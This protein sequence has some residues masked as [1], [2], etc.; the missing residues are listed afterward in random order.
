MLRAVQSSAL[1][2]CAP[3]SHVSSAV[4][5][6]TEQRRR[7]EEDGFLVVENVLDR[8]RT[9]GPLIAEYEA[10]LDRLWQGWIN[11]GALEPGDPGGSFE[12]RIVTAYRAGLE[13]FQPMDISLP[14]GSITEETP[15]HAGPAVFAM[16]T[17]DRLL[18]VVEAIIGPEI[19]SN[20]IQH[21]RIKPP[22][23]DLRDDELRAHIAA[24]DWHQDRAVTLEE[25][26]E[27]RMVTAWVAM[28]DA[29]VENG[30]LQVI[31]GSHR[32]AM[33]PHCPEA[34]QVGIPADSMAGRQAR[35]LPV[36]AGGV[37]LF[38]PLTIHGSLSN[39]SHSVRWSFD[40]RYNVTG[41]STGRP[42]FPS[43]VA[44]S[45][46]AP[47]TVLR[48]PDAWRRMWKAARSRLAQQETTTIHRW[49]PDAAHCA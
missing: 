44:R 30:C 48:D 47:E 38:H 33:I 36:G 16:M 34:G 2:C 4:S 15:F 41:E 45:A 40:I 22:A 12:E 24:T 3:Q 26:D 29:T 32:G 1:R 18:D 19:T 11:S 31:P 25:A 27:T 5:L 14:P 49:A 17:D 37:V 35:P 10:V 13:Y 20:P 9:L 43:F 42:M 23:V 21:V 6:T 39:R 8:T 28:S 46:G 7:F